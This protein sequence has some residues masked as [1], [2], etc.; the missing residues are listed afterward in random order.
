MP[1]ENQEVRRRAQAHLSYLRYRNF[2]DMETHAMHGYM[3]MRVAQFLSV[4]RPW[5]HTVHL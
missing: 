2:Q 5:K 3:R 1:F 4:L